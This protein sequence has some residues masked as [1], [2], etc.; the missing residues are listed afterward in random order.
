MKNGGGGTEDDE[1]DGNI[2]AKGQIAEQN[3]RRGST[4]ISVVFS[5]YN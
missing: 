5:F 3:I 4:G 1:G 2:T